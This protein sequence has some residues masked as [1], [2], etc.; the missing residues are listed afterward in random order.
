MGAVQKR[1]AKWVWDGMDGKL[2]VGY[3][4]AAVAVEV[5]NGLA[6]GGGQ[7][8]T[9]EDA[10]RDRAGAACAQPNA[11]MTTDGSGLLAQLPSSQSAVAVAL[12]LVLR[13]PFFLIGHMSLPILGLCTVPRCTRYNT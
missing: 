4:G 7:L 5:R 12:E 1:A 13:H 11:A 9:V 2:D 10:V 8:V 6:G 3:S